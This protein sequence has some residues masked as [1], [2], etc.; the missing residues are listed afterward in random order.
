MDT[1]RITGAQ[2]LAPALR[3][4]REVNTVPDPV[5]AMLVLIQLDDFKRVDQCSILAARTNI[6]KMC[7]PEEQRAMRPEVLPDQRQIIIAATGLYLSTA[8]SN[9]FDASRRL[10]ILSNLGAGS[11]IVWLVRQNRQHTVQCSDKALNLASLVDLYPFQLFL[12]AFVDGGHAAKEHFSQLIPGANL[13]AVDQ[14]NHQRVTLGFATLLQFRYIVDHRL[15]GKITHLG[16]RDSLE[17]PLQPR[18]RLQPL[19]VINQCFQ[20]LAGRAFR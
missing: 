20:V 1:G 14:S 16:V 11:G 6:E 13:H 19:Q 12:R 18:D 10:K 2:K 5:N 7:E 3:S 15:S 9:L 4:E 17:D 8:L